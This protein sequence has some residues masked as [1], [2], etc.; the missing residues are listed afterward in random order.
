MGS[1][2]PCGEIAV[3]GGEQPPDP[4]LQT[5]PHHRAQCNN[6]LRAPVARKYLKINVKGR[7]NLSNQ[8]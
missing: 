1:I 4:A 2:C 3:V 7:I 8:L 5:A 6:H